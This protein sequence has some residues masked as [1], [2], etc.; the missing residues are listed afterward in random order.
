MKSFKVI[1]LLITVITMYLTVPS[2]SSEVIF[3]TLVSFTGTNGPYPGANPSAALV[4]GE[5]G[6]L[7]G[8]ALNG[9]GANSNGTIF[10]V[11]ADGSVFT[12]LYSFGEGN[13]G[14][15]PLGALIF[16][17]DGNLYGTTYNGGVSNSGTVF[18]FSTNGTYTVLG[19]LGGT[20]GAHPDTALVTGP[21][22]SLYGATRYGGPYPKTTFGGTGYGVVFQITTNGTLLTPVV[23]DVTNGANSAA[24]VPDPDG[25]FYGTT[26][27]GG[28]LSLLPYGFGT[29]Y[30]FNPDGTFTNLYKFSSGDDGGFPVAALVRGNDGNFYGTTENGGTNQLGTVFS[31]TPAGQ[32]KSLY[33]FMSSSAGAYPDGALVQASDGNLYGTTYIGGDNQF[34][35]IFEITTNGNL[36]R[37]VSFTGTGGPSP[38]ANPQSG[39]VQGPDGNF[40]GTTSLGGANGLGTIFRLSVPL[41]PVIEAIT[42]TNDT[43]V[44]TWSAVAG[45][46]YQVLYSDDLTST[47]WLFV[48]K[49]TVATSGIMTATDYDDVAAFTQRYYRVVLE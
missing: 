23:F 12:N 41:P 34:G 4:P 1:P 16:G 8:T 49:P 3:T 36:T 10:E 5:D 27:W 46:T 11:S 44:L 26:E 42:L 20:N 2:A 9:G 48:T 6:N 38:G 40:Y 22:G 21:N 13:N 39:L 25:N 18:Q 17:S 19:L 24:M 47:N 7:Y 37:L 28:T 31:I 29:I 35:T 15:N 45:Q 30:R 32:F 14:A 33:S 43:I